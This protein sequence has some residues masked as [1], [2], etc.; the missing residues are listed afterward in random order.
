MEKIW[1]ALMLG[2]TVLSLLN[3]R[4]GDAASAL[5]SSGEQAVTLLMTL[6][7]TMTLWSGLMEILSEAGDVARL[8]KVFRKIA[9]PLFPGLTDDAAWNAMSMNLSANL[10]GLGNAATPAGIEAAKRLASLGE[11]GLRALAMLLTLDN[12]SLQLIP[13]TVI[14][15]RQAAGAYDPA[16]VWGMTL[17]I[18]G[19]ATCIAIILMKLA[20]LGG[21][22]HER[23]DR[24]SHRGACRNDCTA[25]TD[26]GL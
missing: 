25:G 26:H 2:A 10:L 6:L 24:R 5:L 9:K 23:I 22:E 1:M 21:H 19:A 14:T 12:A 4:A 13:T 16:D 8:G 15:L 11:P 20:I 3:G 17:V 18:S 7:A